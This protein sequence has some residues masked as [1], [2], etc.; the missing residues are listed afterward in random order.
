MCN[1]NIQQA[2]GRITISAQGDGNGHND[3]LQNILFN[4]HIIDKCKKEGL[5]IQEAM[6][7]MKNLKHDEKFM[8]TLYEYQNASA[9][10]IPTKNPGGYIPSN[11]D[12]KRATKVMSEIDALINA[13]TSEVKNNSNMLDKIQ[14]NHPQNQEVQ[15]LKKDFENNVLKNYSLT[16]S[17][18]NELRKSSK[19]FES[20][21]Q[22]QKDNHFIYF[23]FK[24]LS[25]A[26]FRFNSSKALN[27]ISEIYLIPF[28]PLFNC[29]MTSI[30]CKI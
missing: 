19:M 11:G 24:S 28:S 13:K 18:L 12:E 30:T 3:C 29:T 1:N 20:T 4:F 15:T 9:K 16:P 10:F 21:Q 6:N 7:L 17:D 23:P 2:N 5:S 14:A 8:K 27:F 25:F 22:T 26:S